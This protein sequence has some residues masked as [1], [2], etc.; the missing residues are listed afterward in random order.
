MKKYFSDIR[1]ILHSFIGLT[2]GYDITMLLGFTNR[3]NFPLDFRNS[4]S[5]LVG[6]II[7]FW[8]SFYWEK[9]QDKIK[10]NVSDMRDVWNGFAFAYIGGLIALF[11][12]SLLIAG[13]LLLISLILF[14]KK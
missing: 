3:D 8:I 13:V 6:A 7:V 5:A 4:L 2:L 9:Q 14:I 12:P 1:N 10:E 11:L